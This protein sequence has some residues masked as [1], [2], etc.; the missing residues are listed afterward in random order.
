MDQINE[1][2]HALGRVEGELVELSARVSQLE[3][4]Q[5]WVRGGW[6]VIAAVWTSLVCQGLAR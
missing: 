4:W 2:L 6:A 1:I 5:W 3:R